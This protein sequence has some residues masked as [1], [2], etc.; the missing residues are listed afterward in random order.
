VVVLAGLVLIQATLLTRLRFF[1]TAPNLLLV[2]VIGWSLLQGI[3]EGL[4]W[5]FI[6]G[7]GIDLVAG[8][9]LGTSSIALMAISFLA[10]IGKTTVFPGN[11]TLPVFI[12]ALATPVHG[13]I[14]LLIETLRGMPINWV[15]QTVQVIAPELLL[16]A[17]LTILAYPVLRGLNRVI[18]RSNTEL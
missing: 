8:M 16:N 1:G 13:W 17:A 7:L 6:G 5:G 15:T 4:L 10:K 11:L 18:G 2:A 3:E 9:P 14:V 12:V